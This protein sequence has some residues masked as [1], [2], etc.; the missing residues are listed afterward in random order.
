[1]PSLRDTEE[2]GTPAS[3]EQCAA[4]VTVVVDMTAADMDSEQIRTLTKLVKRRGY[5]EAEIAYAVDQLLYDPET[6]KKLRFDGGRITPADFERIIR[7]HR[8]M[9]KKLERTLTLFERNRLLDQWPERLSVEDFGIVGY[10]QDDEPKYRYFVQKEATRP[11]TPNPQLRNTTPGADRTRNDDAGE[12]GH[13]PV[14]L[15]DALNAPTE[16][17][18]DE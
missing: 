14:S 3:P 16:D 1:M 7:P 8:H 13:T 5:T 11:P 12:N 6:E 18:D 17:E 15:T 2:W 4:A 10:T 9:R